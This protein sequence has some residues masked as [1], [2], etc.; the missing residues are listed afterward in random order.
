MPSPKTIQLE[1]V[2]PVTFP[3][4]ATQ[5]EIEEALN[6]DF[7]GKPAPSP[8]ETAAE[9]AIEAT[10]PGAAFMAGAIPGASIG[11]TLGSA[12]PVVGTAIGGILGGMATGIPAQILAT[13]AQKKVAEFVDPE[14]AKE[15]YDRLEEG[16]RVNPWSAA[17]GAVPAMGVSARTAPFKLAQLPFRGALGASMAVGLPVL[18]EQRLP[19]A[20][21]LVS[22]TLMGTIFGE[23]RFSKAGVRRTPASE[24]TR[25]ARANDLLSRAREQGHEWEITHEPLNRPGDVVNIEPGSNKAKVNWENLHE[26]L[27]QD[28]P[29]DISPERA[30]EDLIQHETR[31]TATSMEQAKEFWKNLSPYE[32]YLE[33]RRLHGQNYTGPA[34]SDE[35]YG[36]EAIRFWTQ[37]AQTKSATEFISSL[38]QENRTAKFLTGVQRIVRW[39]RANLGK[40][41]SKEAVRRNKEILDEV[42]AK[43]EQAK[44]E[45]KKGAPDAL[46]PETAQTVR[47]VREESTGE[48]Q[49]SEA[50]R[51]A[52]D[53]ER[54][55]QEEL[56][57]KAQ[58]SLTPE[59]QA[60]LGKRQ[61]E[62]IEGLQPGEV[63]L[64]SAVMG[65]SKDPNK[66]GEPQ[67][68]PNHPGILEQMGGVELR[69]KYSS[70]ESRD[71][72]DFG[73]RTNQREFVPRTDL[74]VRKTGK[75][76]HSDDIPSVVEKGK[77]V[78]DQKGQA[79]GLPGWA[80][81]AMIR[82]GLDPARTFNDIDLQN[83]SV[84]EAILSDPTLSVEQKQLLLKTGSLGSGKK[85]VKFTDVTPGKKAGEVKFVAEQAPPAAPTGEAPTPQVATGKATTTPVA[86]TAGVPAATPSIST[87]FPEVKMRELE[88]LNQKITD[89]NWKY[90]KAQYDRWIQLSDELSAAEQAAG[91]APQSQGGAPLAMSRK[92]ADP[93][94]VAKEIGFTH[95]P[96]PQIGAMKLTGMKPEDLQKLRDGGFKL[97]WEFTDFR[98][99]SPTKGISF[100]VNEGASREEIISRANEKR[101][102]AGLEPLAMSR[103]TQYTEGGELTPKG[104]AVRLID[105]VGGITKDVSRRI[106]VEDAFKRI[107]QLPKEQW[108]QA[109]TDFHAQWKQKTI[110]DAAQEIAGKQ[111]MAELGLSGQDLTKALSPENI[112]AKFGAVDR[113]AAYRSAIYVLNMKPKGYPID[114]TVEVSGKTVPTIKSGFQVGDYKEFWD[115]FHERHPELPE[116]VAEEVWDN[117]VMDVLNNASGERLIELLRPARLEKKYL[118]HETK[119]ELQ[120]SVADPDPDPIISEMLKSPIPFG[121][122]PPSPHQSLAFRKFFESRDMT[123]AQAL[124][125]LNLLESIKTKE[126]RERFAWLKGQAEMKTR[127]GKSV[128]PLGREEMSKAEQ[129]DLD[130]LWK[131]GRAEASRRRQNII[132]DLSKWLSRSDKRKAANPVR[133]EFTLDDV[134]FETDEPSG[135]YAYYTPRQ[136]SDTPFLKATLGKGGSVGKIAGSKLSRSIAILSDPKTGD[137]HA[138]SVY[139]RDNE[140]M[141]YDPSGIVGSKEKGFLSLNKILAKYN[142]V[143]HL[144]LRDPVTRLH[145]RWSPLDLREYDRIL[146]ERLAEIEKIKARNE[147]TARLNKDLP[148]E[149]QKPLAVVPE[150]KITSPEAVAKARL[151][152]NL[153]KVENKDGSIT[154][155]GVLPKEQRV[156]P[157]GKDMYM[158][159]IGEVAQY[160]ENESMTQW[161][162]YLKEKKQQRAEEIEEAYQKRFEE[163]EED[164]GTETSEDE[165]TVRQRIAQLREEEGLKPW[166][167]AEDYDPETLEGRVSPLNRASIEAWLRGGHGGLMMFKSDLRSIAEHPLTGFEAES[168]FKVIRDRKVKH[169]LDLQ[170]ALDEIQKRYQETGANR[171][172][173]LGAQYAFDKIVNRVFERMMASPS[174]KARLA[175]FPPIPKDV[176]YIDM[177][178]DEKAHYNE[179]EAI[180]FRALLRTFRE[181]YDLSEQ[182]RTTDER[183]KAAASKGVSLPEDI[184]AFRTKA[185]DQYGDTARRDVEQ[186]AAQEKLTVSRPYEGRPVPRVLGKMPKPGVEIPYNRLI[187]WQE[188]QGY[189]QR[190]LPVKEPKKLSA[191]E[192]RFVKSLLNREKPPGPKLKP[193]EVEAQRKLWEAQR[194][195]LRPEFSPSGPGIEKAAYEQ[196]LARMTWTT[197]DQTKLAMT[198]KG[199]GPAKRYQEELIAQGRAVAPPESYDVSIPK[200]QLI[201]QGRDLV[202]SGKIN[203]EKEMRQFERTGYMSVESSLA[204]RY[205]GY[206]LQSMADSAAANPGRNSEQFRT[207]EALSASWMKRIDKSSKKQFA[208]IGHGLQGWNQIGPDDMRSTTF[209]R[210]FLRKAKAKRMG[211]EEGEEVDLDEA[212]ENA[213][214]EIVSKAKQSEDSRHLTEMQIGETA[215][216]DA[217]PPI[218]EGQKTIIKNA[219]Q[220]ADKNYSDSAYLLR[221]LK[222]TGSAMAMKGKEGELPPLD[223]IEE[224]ALGNVGMRVMQKLSKSNEMTDARWLEEMRKLLSSDEIQRP[225]LEPY[226]PHIRAVSEEINKT[227]INNFV[228]TGDAVKDARYIFSRKR[229][230]IEESMAAIRRA[231][232]AD[233]SGKNISPAEAFHI[234]NYIKQ[235]FLDKGIIDF[236]RIRM[237][238]SADLGIK[239]ESG[240]K[241]VTPYDQVRLFRAMSAKRSMRTLTKDLIDRMR[242]ETRVKSQA[243][244]WLKNQQFPGWLR[245]A[246]A[247]PRMF[248]WD[249]ILGHGLVPMVTHASNMIFNPYAWSVYFGTWKNGKYVPGAWHQMYTMTFGERPLQRMLGD[250][251]GL[252]AKEYHK[253]VLDEMQNH[254]RFN[255]WKN[256]AKLECDPFKYTDDYQIEALKSVF[257]KKMEWLTAGPGF[258][259]LKTLRFSMAEKWF[260]SLPE[261]L[262]NKESAILIADSVNHATGIVKTRFHES[263]N[264]LMFAP[265]LEASRWAYL[266]KDT[267]KA[268]DYIRNWRTASLEQR[269]W[270]KSELMQ[271]ASVFAGYYAALVANQA[272]LKLCNSDEKINFNDPKKGDFMAF[273]VAGFKVGV[274]NPFIGMIRLFS[275]AI[276]ASVGERT[277]FE[278]MTSRQKQLAEDAWSYGRGKFS[279][280]A[281]FGIDIATQ[282]DFRRRPLPWSRE[283]LTKR[284]YLSGVKQYKT[285]EYLAATFTP[286]PIEESIRES[287]RLHGMDEPTINK[288]MKVMFIAGSMAA[289]GARVTEDK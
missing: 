256:E 273:K 147:E 216:A 181:V 76:P 254:E 93:F 96:E 202:I 72:S 272:F 229:P 168:L 250:K 42:E 279:P 113:A 183:A 157:N 18:T 199:W 287:F 135:A 129:D 210:R 286:I 112:K 150:V 281:S 41:L 35:Q 108:G 235:K 226:L 197:G 163:E 15:F 13:K 230:P 224:D 179:V 73:Y 144:L 259:A 271:K 51:R 142:V 56:A 284:Q 218:S 30:L 215:A 283:P 209:V 184:I 159:D 115:D 187:Q 214:D 111:A 223:P 172:S 95:N 257:G 31:H 225:D 261:H 104:V 186:A 221:G 248:F 237:E 255:F 122:G 193:W 83:P 120:R 152:K 182:S 149:K 213:A 205:W 121:V 29:K 43:V 36:A 201:A 153:I 267:I 77:L 251:R 233:P 20:P 23:H 9:S 239:D 143:A 162:Q 263:L 161:I 228:G 158:S 110:E 92:P 177:T 175:K 131:Q 63:I 141:I 98:P 57:Q 289:T 207:L 243:A 241:I 102:A 61:H 282:E 151:N 103:K 40:D 100:Y 10:I 217:D 126:M 79:S 54:R 16:R 21:E 185:L 6:R 204:F 262:R 277:A 132:S 246:R 146:S 62:V 278:R 288:V 196:K 227:F 136:Q 269:A 94:E 19:T 8:L 164:T 46:D 160:Y 71:T 59:E 148:K 258:D 155:T 32:K 195:G 234:W 68:G 219:E 64:E 134:W 274:M 270:A 26:Y 280:F 139:I 145:K 109:L 260:N 91:S 252:T 133:N 285:G 206:R 208:K 117:A 39:T 203:P 247:F 119:K 190:P 173:D 75:L 78:G 165:P 85:K 5:E 178:P 116:W 49:V 192:A 58:V 44:E 101:S 176:E 268:I 249:K 140:P 37:L 125:A 52:A 1:G 244:N 27:E 7:G 236:R 128:K 212:E 174:E 22:G 28:L 231:L 194:T 130:L 220:Q 55:R 53:D 86:T 67:Y 89:P 167:S 50:E 60:E 88:S 12:I 232:E 264:W 180:K 242:E 11:A 188:R 275:N 2:G 65:P 200:E 245:T 238:A 105:S 266:F 265:K 87:S 166:E 24:E 170:R 69:D 74:K 171:G 118:G 97:S 82:A 127:S 211:R 123:P 137:H 47:D 253:L 99:D 276:H 81:E 138:V 124:D 80:R 189:P 70:R 154:V 169:P 114:A 156:Y 222:K 25:L 106:V 3:E 34:L 66:W 38:K 198:R 48:Q 84:R 107:T 90:D 14:G 45:L 4:D 191:A 240:Q 17:L 33:K